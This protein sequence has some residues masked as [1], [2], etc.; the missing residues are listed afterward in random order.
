MIT[1][2]ST[3]YNTKNLAHLQ[4]FTQSHK[5]KCKHA[6]T[7]TTIPL[8]GSK[9]EKHEPSKVKLKLTKKNLKAKYPVGK[10][11]A[12]LAKATLC[13]CQTHE[14]LIESATRTTSEERRT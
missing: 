12:L 5:T 6:T 14:G 9:S 2:R 11:N 1:T 4:L 13:V 3:N 7:H 8:E 10:I